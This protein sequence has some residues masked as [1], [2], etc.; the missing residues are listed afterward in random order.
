MPAAM[1]RARAGLLV[2][3]TSLVTSLGAAAC[4]DPDPGPQGDATGRI[5]HYD[6][7]FDLETRA[8]HARLTAVLDAPGH[9]L[10]LP[11]RAEGLDPESPLVDG[12]PIVTGSAVGDGTLTLCGA[13]GHHAGETMTLDVDVTI[14]LA[15]LSSSQVGYSITPDAEGNPF[16][17]LV[18]WVGGCDRFGP[19]DARPDQFSTYT[20][21]VTHPAGFAVRCPGTITERG[22][23]ETECDFT[24]DG[25]PTYSTFGV[26]A[27]PAWT[28][29]DKGRWGSTRVTLYDRAQTGVDAAIDAA[30]HAGFVELLEATFGPYPYGDELRILTAPTYWNGFE[31]PGNIVLDDQLAR[32][33]SA[34]LHPVA[35]VLDHEIAHQW[36]GDQTTLAGTY[37]FVWKEAMAEYLT[38]LYEAQADPPAATATA[39]AWKQFAAGARFHPV[40]DEQPELFTYYGDVYGQGP[41]IL[42]R[43]LEVLSSRAQVIAALQRVLGAPRALSVAEVVTALEATTGL[44]L[45]DYA[46]AWIYGAGAPVWPRVATTFTPGATTSQLAVT[47]SGGTDRRCKFHVALDGD[48]GARVLVA[49]DT[50]R[51]DLAQTI[52]VPTPAFEVRRVV[53]DPLSECLVQPAALAAPAPAPDHHPW[54]S[55]RALTRK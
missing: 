10:T 17:Y 34:Y 31:H 54:R 27:Y 43:Q 2:T 52:A 12:A 20:F 49:V 44:D 53:L 19:C 35:H 3:L 8:A 39:A 13:R 6:Y 16:Y 15:T 18:S 41:M 33:R 45:A 40:P 14:P 46:A 48:D 1:R 51:G 42:F 47:V 28:Q 37:E 50:F 55:A 21:T 7:R 30:Y 5:A 24:H 11:Y 9:C 26:A 23:T 22:P 25:G 32:A 29:I 38:F 36:A 4:G